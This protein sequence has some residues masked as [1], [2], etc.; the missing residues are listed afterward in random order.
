M[1]DLEERA[2]AEEEFRKLR[3]VLPQY[4]CVYTADVRPLYASEELLEYF[5][6]TQEDFR[7]DD[8]Q[9]RAFHPEDLERIKPLREA[10]MARGE[11]W[12][13][14][15]RIKRR[16]GQY[17]WFLIRGKPLRD[18]AGQIVR[19]FSSGADI[20]D[21]KQAQ[22][23]VQRK[24]EIQ[25][26]F[27]QLID[28][29]MDGIL[30][31]DRDG[32]YIV[33][34]PGLERIFGIKEVERLGKQATDLCPFFRLSG[35]ENCYAETLL[36]RGIVASNIPYTLSDTGKEIYLDGQFSPLLNM[37]GAAIGG[38][39]IIRDVT[40]RKQA[41]EALRRNEAYLAEAQRLSH[42]G[43]FAHDPIHGEITYWSAETY[44]TFG[45]DPTNGLISFQA[46]RSR[47][48]ADDLK[49]FDAARER[50]ISDK[51]GVEV[52]FRIVLPDNSIKH[53]HC[54]S[55]PVLNSAGEVVE[56][57]GTNVD[58][59]EQ[60]EARIALE[61]A[62]EEIKKLKDE[63]YHEN[64]ALREEID[65]ASMFEEI[66]GASEVLRSVLVQL[67]KVAPTDSTVLITGETGTGKELVARAIH[68]RSQRAARPFVSVNCAAI[69]AGLIGSELFGHEKGAF[70][71][72]TQRRLGR[73]ELANGGTLFLDEVGDL[74]AE[75]Q[76]ALLRVL[77]ERQFERVGG[78]RA[79]D[80]DVRI[81]TA[82]N[83]DLKAAVAAGAF[84]EDLYYRLNVFP[85]AVPALRERKDDIPLL[86]EY[87]TDRYAS[88]AGK[89]IMSIDKRTL[90]LF[91]RYHWPGNIRELQNVIERGVILCDGDTFSIDESWLQ[92]DLSQPTEPSG[93]GLA[94]PGAEEE[95][96]L[97]E[98][99]L[100]ASN[101]RIAGRN[102]AAAKLGIPRST[103]ETKIK[104]LGIAKYKFKAA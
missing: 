61:K 27:K 17:R 41:E 99:A 7:A 88:K 48:H 4:M 86:V 63:L 34:N 37:N 91:T 92:L 76:I 40:E 104:K 75:T 33:W 64:L 89:K 5:G 83:R 12:N 81:I 57:V 30:A 35:G 29:S 78:A 15:T 2:Q 60:Y 97:I 54:V 58:I 32:R 103:L 62:F 45:F 49:K 96:K 59:T 46:A 16:D 44:R 18:D 38:M 82:T 26:V 21:L 72:A 71:G 67:A 101:G 28:S 8:F 73:F 70:T 22:Q 80:A 31:F 25:A 14:E 42:T 24:T 47:V 100:A 50:G 6:F 43:S 23:E 98:T 55:R 66:V 65:H 74:P 13:V 94:R 85:I 77:Q 9:T 1:S 10:A 52:D 20:D 79:L 36:G 84:R 11:G 93:N 53:I 87:F 102:G 68:K 90:D 19:W 56:I 39:A 3:E 51:T 69:P 95:R